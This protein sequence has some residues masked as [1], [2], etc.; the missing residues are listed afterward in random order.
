MPFELTNVSTIFQIYIN[1]ALK[2]LLDIIYITFINDIGI[3]SNSVEKYA[4]HVR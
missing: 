3:Y 2:G 4:D 1:E